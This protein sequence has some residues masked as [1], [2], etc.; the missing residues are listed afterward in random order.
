LTL[1]LPEKFS[2]DLIIA[3]KVHTARQTLP[4][5]VSIVTQAEESSFNLSSAFSFRSCSYKHIDIAL[6]LQLYFSLVLYLYCSLC[7]LE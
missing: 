2:L 1:K 5:L 3:F 6:P 7:N 4:Q